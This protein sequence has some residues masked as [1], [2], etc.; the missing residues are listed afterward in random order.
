MSN[1]SFF[2]V[3]LEKET[4]TPTR[5][6]TFDGTDFPRGKNKFKKMYIKLFKKD[7]KRK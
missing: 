7:N 5:W 4:N 6:F 3:I 1:Y 2:S